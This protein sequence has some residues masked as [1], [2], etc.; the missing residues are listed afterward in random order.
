[1]FVIIM[2][3]KR[4]RLYRNKARSLLIH[5]CFHLLP[6]SRLSYGVFGLSTFCDMKTAPSAMT[7]SLMQKLNMIE[8][9]NM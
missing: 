3:V 2:R 1:M 9:D 6:I 5:N 8:Y 4:V 7:Y